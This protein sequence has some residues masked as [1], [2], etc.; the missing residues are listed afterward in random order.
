MN[1]LSGCICGD[2]RHRSMGNDMGSIQIHKYMFQINYSLN[3]K[4][5]IAHLVS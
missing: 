1:Y 2:K 3:N 4:T 5:H